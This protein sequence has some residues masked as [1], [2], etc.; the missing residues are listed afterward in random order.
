MKD[1]T[2]SSNFSLNCKGKLTVYKQPIVMGIINT[3]PDSFHSNSRSKNVKMGIAKARKMVNEGADILDI[4]GYSSRPGADHISTAVE[5]E[6]VVPMIKEIRAEFPN[7]KISIDTF[8]TEVAE[9]AILSG[10]DFIND[11]KGGF[12]NPSIFEIANQY[13]TPYILMHMQGSPQDMQLYTNYQSL[14]KE[15]TYYF[16]S[17]LEIA[18]KYGLTDII[19]DV[20][21]G[22][23]KSIEQNF[24]LLK[25]LSDFK[26]FEKPLL[27]GVSRKSLIQKTIGTS[28]LESL[29]GTTVLNSVGLLNGANILRVHDVKEAKES[30]KLISKLNG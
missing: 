19:L 23:S 9:A 14:I 25:R 26:I 16:S 6:R 11:I 5:I 13:K 21:I 22:F 4:G 18:N 3:T 29:N 15:I 28:A 17:Q 8:R 7:Q 10:A 24:T 20:G 12:N 30:I 27:L 2:F 1:T